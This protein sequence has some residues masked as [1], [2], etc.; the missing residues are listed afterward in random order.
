MES[1]FKHYLELQHY[2]GEI[3]NPSVKYGLPG[4]RL[5]IAYADELA[6]GCIALRRLSETACEMKRLYVRP[7]FRD[8]GLARRLTG[9]IISEA[10][11]IGYRYMLLDTLPGL[12]SAIKLYE[13]MGF[14]RIPPYNDSP[15]DKTVFM[16]L[17]M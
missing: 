9:L 1:G 13:S 5:Y 8:Q 6:A 3:A 2:G 15:V 12:E 4:G 16:R 7:E 10:K 14:Y 17:D 11:K